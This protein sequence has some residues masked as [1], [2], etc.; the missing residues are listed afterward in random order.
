MVNPEDR[1]AKVRNDDDPM[2]D[3]FH[4]G[5]Y[6]GYFRDVDYLDYSDSG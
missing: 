2:Y 5:D 6:F 4:D 1:N 3:Y